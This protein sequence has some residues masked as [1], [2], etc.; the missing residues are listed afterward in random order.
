MTLLCPPADNQSYNGVVRVNHLLPVMVMVV[1]CI[2]DYWHPLR[3]QSSVRLRAPLVA[4][5][6][7]PLRVLQWAGI[8][9]CLL[10]LLVYFRYQRSI[11][12]SLRIVDARLSR[13][14]VYRDKQSKPQ[15]VVK[16]LELHPQ[17]VES[18]PGWQLCSLGEYLNTLRFITDVA[19][20]NE[21]SIKVP[22][23]QDTRTRIASGHGGD[24]VAPFGTALGRGPA[25]RARHPKSGN[26]G[27]TIGVATV[28]VDCRQR[29]GVARRQDCLGPHWR[30][31]VHA[32]QRQRVDQF[33][34]F[35]SK[36][37]GRE[38]GGT[39]DSVDGPWRNC[40]R[41]DVLQ[42]Q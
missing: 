34:Q 8:A 18:H 13:G 33:C 3:P 11:R 42:Q 16:V 6:D 20:N 21:R 40:L 10:A 2:L 28:V 29:L 41:P 4:I 23:T 35:E 32:V 26:L 5:L 22:L 27:G 39:A 14:L 36:V 1:V 12:K 15:K 17:F 24:P 30:Q 38:H 9:V 19:E 7:A 31:G 25:A 37:S